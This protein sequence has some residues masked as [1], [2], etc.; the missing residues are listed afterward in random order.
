MN[1]ADLK[2]F[3]AY[4]ANTLK[5]IAKYHGISTGRKKDG[6]V[7]NL[8]KWAFDVRRITKVQAEL[9]EAERT[10][11]TR[12]IQFGGTVRSN[13]LVK[14]LLQDG[15]I[16]PVE[17]SQDTRKN[18]QHK[19]NP[20]ASGKLTYADLLA[21]LLLKGLVFSHTPW[22]ETATVV[23][24]SA[25]Q[26]IF[27]PSFMAAILKKGQL[28]D[29]PDPKLITPNY[30]TNGSVVTS[31]R[32]INNY[33]RG[34]RAADGINLTTQNY[35]YKTAL[36]K[37]AEQ[38]A[39]PT[40]LKAGKSESDNG[41]LFFLRRIL[42]AATLL[43]RKQGNKLIATDTQH[44]F[45]GLDSAERIHTLFETWRDGKVWNGLQFLSHYER[46]R[47]LTDP[48][49]AELSKSR[50]V[51][52][53]QLKTMGS[54]W[55]SLDSVVDAIQAK[56]YGFLFPERDTTPY[57]SSY[58]Y[59]YQSSSKFER[60]PYTER[61]NPYH[62]S[63]KY[64][65]D[66]ADGWYKVEAAYI[67]HV[68]AGPLHWLGLV[69]LGYLNPPPEGDL[70]GAAPFDGYRLT[71][72]GEWLLGLSDRP[73]VEASSGGGIILQPNFEILAMEPI[74][75]EVLMTLDAF[76]KVKDSQQRVTT[77]E[78]TRESVYRGQQGRWQVADIQAFF[79]QH[80]KLPMPDNVRRTLDEWDGLFKRV[81]IRR[82]V[83][84]A[85]VANAEIG[86]KLAQLA[87]VERATETVLHSKLSFYKM[88]QVVREA[89]YLPL[90]TP[91]GQVIAKDSV[92]ISDEGQVTFLHPVPSIFAKQLLSEISAELNP[93]QWQILPSMVKS[94]TNAGAYFEEFFGRIQ[95]LHAGKISPKLANNFKAWANYYGDAKQAQ[96]ILIEFKDKKTRDEL[97]AD[98]ELHKHLTPFAGMR[99]LAIID[100]A[101]VEQVHK[102]LAE[103]GVNI[104]DNLN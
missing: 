98:P 17:G 18:A 47:A 41:Y 68:I 29:L 70:C 62:L 103:R 66:E 93:Q 52:L 49:P 104:T 40:N 91:K 85:E 31:Q 73:T 77:Y 56:Y 97:C 42:T 25:G 48:A 28:V 26:T 21:K 2:V 100:E 87:Q 92:K 83:S 35:L 67:A 84:L 13:R 57:Y 36:K 74:D 69:D 43:Q 65:R 89:G 16:I 61:N 22:S 1:Q 94:H 95:Q 90:K 59:S 75:I 7:F 3:Q 71:A 58:Y 54:G 81:T 44:R 76:S 11:V 34:V 20:K 79:A 15:V 39:G 82:N 53:D 78:L 14:W 51:I 32:D 55:I 80:S 30:I 24:W 101:H 96:L 4:N 27:I 9:S 45:W 102:A 37:L 6:T 33:V 50:R 8:A 5:G 99:P 38:I 60:S 12:I 23:D 72:H 88:A 63:F 46:G 64:I 19:G 86:D 10:A